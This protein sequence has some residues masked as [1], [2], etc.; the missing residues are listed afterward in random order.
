MALRA[1]HGFVSFF[2][3]FMLGCSSS[4]GGGVVRGDGGGGDTSG[5]VP[6]I[7]ALTCFDAVDNDLDGLTDCDDPGCATFSMCGGTV[8]AS[9]P[10][11]DAFTTCESI[12]NE[13][14]NLFAPVDL[15]WVVDSSGSM[16]NDRRVIQDNMEVFTSF[17]RTAGIDF[18]VVLVSSGSI[19]PSPLFSSDPRFLF[20]DRGVGSQEVFARALDAFP[21]YMAHLRPDAITHIIGVTDDD[22]DIRAGTFISMMQGLLGHDFTF[23]A[24]AS[25]EVPNPVPFLDPIPCTRPDDVVGVVPI[26][27][28]AV[29]EEYFD[30]ATATGGL[31]FSICTD[32]WSALFSTLG[33]TVAVSEALPCAFALPEPPA[34]MAFNPDKVNVDHTP[35]AG[36]SATFP[37]TGSEA[38]CAGDAA[39]HYDDASMP[40]QVLLCPA[41][42]DLVNA[43]PGRV[44]IALGCDTL[45]I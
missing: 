44:D 10:P 36:S 17:I 19:D 4:G 28:A 33:M 18:H 37:R 21:S 14:E 34:G 23:H 3:F 7:D 13:A 43:T 6:E 16:D 5:P 31:D 24:I 8:D 9:M 27:A 30:A 12:A 15:I 41:A 22:D 42:C 32:N 26:P 39:W 38:E 29:G 45:L 1:R 11:S 35:E 20:I 25:P 40:T 2:V